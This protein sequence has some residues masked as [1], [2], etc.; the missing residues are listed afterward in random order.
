MRQDAPHDAHA[1]PS[2]NP[3]TTMKHFKPYPDTPP[4]TRT[5]APC[6]AR[7]TGLFICPRDHT[8]ALPRVGQ[9]DG[10]KIS[11]RRLDREEHR[12]QH[13]II[14]PQQRH[15]GH[16]LEAGSTLD[17]HAVCNASGSHQTRESRIQC[18]PATNVQVSDQPNE[19][20]QPP[21]RRGSRHQ[22]LAATVTNSAIR[23]SKRV[24]TVPSVSRL[25]VAV[26]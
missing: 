24:Q 14:R 22:S 10:F 19:D 21:L 6:Q 17:R 25:R 7:P 4:T 9:G 1:A 3:P 11:T 13:H 20:Q 5:R 26:G 15:A 23:R 8:M 2:S 16:Q 12:R 18:E